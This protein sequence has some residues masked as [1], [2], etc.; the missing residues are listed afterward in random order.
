M[1]LGQRLSLELLGSFLHRVSDRVGWG[2]GEQLLKP[3]HA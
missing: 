2:E 3:G 1:A